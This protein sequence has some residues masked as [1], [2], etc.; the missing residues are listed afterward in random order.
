M[1]KNEIENIDNDKVQQDFR[2]DLFDRYGE[3]FAN[4]ECDIIYEMCRPILE[5]IRK[6]SSS[7]CELKFI[8]DDFGIQILEEIIRV[9]SLIAEDGERVRKGRC[10]VT[11]R[12][13]F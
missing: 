3:Y 5:Y 13:Y 7:G 9:D 1:E 8:I 11:T 12:P 6:A 4:K 10:F 2:R